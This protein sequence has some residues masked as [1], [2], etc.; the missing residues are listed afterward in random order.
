VLHRQLHRTIQ[1]FGARTHHTAF[2]ALEL[3][4]EETMLSPLQRALTLSL[5]S[6]VRG[7][8]IAMQTRLRHPPSSRT[9]T[10][11]SRKYSREMA[12]IC[13]SSF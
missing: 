6:S 5:N 3:A 10:D 12:L 13:K 4:S 1:P 11:Q 9:G 2:P 7:V 8:G